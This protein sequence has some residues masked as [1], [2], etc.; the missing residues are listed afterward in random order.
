MSPSGFLHLGIA[1]V[2][3]PDEKLFTVLKGA[4]V[5]RISKFRTHWLD[6]TARASATMKQPH[7]NLSIALMQMPERALCK[8]NAQGLSDLR[9]GLREHCNSRAIFLHSGKEHRR[10]IFASSIR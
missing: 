5:R 9:H 8:F 7:T 4:A 2:I 1:T 3:Q 6:N 10:N